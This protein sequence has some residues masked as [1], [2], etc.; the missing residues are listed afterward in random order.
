[1]ITPFRVLFVGR[2]ERFKGV[3]DLLD[4]AQ[5]FSSEAQD[6]IFDLWDRRS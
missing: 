2:I 1:M 3:F 6:I 4:I 5:R